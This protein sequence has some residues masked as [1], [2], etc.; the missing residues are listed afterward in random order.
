MLT[1]GGVL[2][3]GMLEGIVIGA[4][5]S[6]LLLAYR[7]SKPRVDVLGRVPGTDDFASIARHPDYQT[8]PGTLIVRIDGGIYYAN[9]DAVK[10]RIDELATAADPPITRLVVDL[11]NV[12]GLDIAAMDM[13]NELRESGEQNGYAVEAVGATGSVR[14]LLNQDGLESLLLRPTGPTS[15]DEAVPD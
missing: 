6:L 15:V 3:F 8:T 2:T 9:A 14:H 4:G 11:D 12:G 1:A 13:L 7:S 10:D 5:F